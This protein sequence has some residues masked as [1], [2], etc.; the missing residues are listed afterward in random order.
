MEQN[1]IGRGTIV[2]KAQRDETAN[3][4][5]SWLILAVNKGK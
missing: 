4:K 1:I 5:H 2:C 3:G